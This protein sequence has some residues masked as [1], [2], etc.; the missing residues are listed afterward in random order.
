MS[1]TEEIFFSDLLKQFRKRRK[2]SQKELAALIGVSR[3][4]VGL[5]ERGYYKP[6]TDTI[7]YELAGVL[8]LSEQERDQFFQAYSVTALRPSFR[9]PPTRRNPYFTGREGRLHTLHQLLSTGKQVALTQAISINGL[10]G[11]G[12]TQMALEYAYRYQRSYHDILWAIADS[13]E[14]LATSYTQLAASLQLREK[15]EKDQ[16]KVIEAVKLWLHEHRGWLLVL[17][18]IEDLSL[19]GQFVPVDRQGAVLLTTRKNVT[20]PV[21]EAFAL[22]VMTDR[23]G[24][25]FLLKRA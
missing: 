6:E 2:L 13:P 25:L 18:N 15:E 14:T 17:D 23:E 3:E 7:L 4:S 16:T 5:W 9:N 11:I 22:D 24:T 20:M 12:K 21:A 19:V 8:D 1:Q 10:G